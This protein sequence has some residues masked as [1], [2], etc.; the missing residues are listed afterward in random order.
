VV[1]ITI[2]NTSSGGIKETTEIRHLDWQPTEHKDYI[3]GHVKGSSRY[4]PTKELDNE[5][6]KTGWLEETLQGECIQNDSES[7]DGSWS[8]SMVCFS[9][10]LLDA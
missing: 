3:W 2:R 10:A 7:W 5:F 6:L 4:L 1:T 9:S 8:S